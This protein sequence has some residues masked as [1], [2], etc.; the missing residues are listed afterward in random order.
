MATVTFEARDVLWQYWTGGSKCEQMQFVFHFGKYP[1][2]YVSA[3]NKVPLYLSEQ[4]FGAKALN[5]ST[6][7]L[8]PACAPTL[9]M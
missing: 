5:K 1:F 8:S 6:E 4:I 7:N 2:C 9:V 3:D